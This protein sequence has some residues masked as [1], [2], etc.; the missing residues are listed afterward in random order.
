MDLRVQ[1]KEEIAEFL[2]QNYGWDGVFSEIEIQDTRKEFEGEFT[3]VVF[4]YLRIARSKPEQ[5]ADSVGKYLSEKLD[6]VESYNVVKGFLNIS[7]SSDGWYDFLQSEIEAE[8]NYD[9][10]AEKILVEFCSPNTNKPLHLGHIRNILLGDSLSRIL[11]A[12]GHEVINTQVI[13]DRG[14]AISKSMLAW[15]R[16]GNGE[17]PENA[18]VKGDHYV[19]S[20]YV[21]FDQK[22]AEEYK[23]WQSTELSEE[24]YR[25]RKQGDETTEVFFSRYKNEYFNRY[26]VLGKEA[27]ALLI[28][29]EDDEEEAR[30]VWEMM[31]GWVLDG[32]EETFKKLNVSFDKN[33]FESDTYLSGRAVVEQGEKDGVFQ[34]HEDGS[35]WVDLTENGL[36]KKILLRA[37]G[38]SLYTTQ[39]IGTAQLRYDDYAMDRMIYVVGDEQEYHFQALFAVL[40]RLGVSYTDGL[41]HLSYGMVDLPSGKMKSREGNVVDADDLVQE[42]IDAVIDNT[43]DRGEL[44]S[45]SKEEYSKTIHNIAMGALKF[46]ILQVNP[47]RRMLYDPQQSVDLQGHTGPYVQNAYVRIQSLLRK[48][49]LVKSDKTQAVIIEL[50]EYERLLLSELHTTRDKVLQAAMDYNPSIVADQAYG[51]AKAFHRFYHEV[52]ILRTENEEIKEFRINLCQVTARHLEYLFGLLNVDMPE[53]M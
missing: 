20:F 4:P 39:D 50:N 46:F 41:F 35:V 14:I 34:R 6:Y 38:T 45:L 52:P 7:I 51:I 10:A 22:L 12:V 5:L 26:S 8:F 44:D 9:V 48:H 40:E 21:L 42:V 16:W 24:V 23:I 25:E 1:I 19:G 13:N 3:F 29:W 37:D 28:R 27:R 31:N 2:T 17:N 53:R 32:F 43:K 15:M 33:Y 49:S 11:K 30:S 47:R 36:D 18:G